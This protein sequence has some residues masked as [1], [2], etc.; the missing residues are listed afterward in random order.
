MGRVEAVPGSLLQT[1]AH[2]A[3]DARRD[4]PARPGHLGRVLL[5]DRVHRL[6]RA[7]ASERAHAREHLVKQRPEREDVRAVIHRLA[8]DLLGRHEAHRPQH[9]A[10]FRGPRALVSFA[11]ER[12]RA[13][14]LGEAEV[15]D[16]DPAVVRD[17]DVVGLEVAV[18]DPLVVSG[19]KAAGDLQRV[20]EGLADRKRSALEADL[21]GVAFEQLRDDV[22]GA[23]VRADIVDGEDVR[24]VQGAG[25]AGLLLEAA[26]LLGIGDLLGENLDRDL[27]LQAG[28]TGAVDLTHRPR[29]EQPHDLVRAESRAGLE[30]HRYTPA[31]SPLSL[32][33]TDCR[34]VKTRIAAMTGINRRR[35]R[36]LSIRHV[37]AAGGHRSVTTRET[38]CGAAGPGSGS[39]SAGDRGAGLSSG[40]SSPDR[41]LRRL[42]PAIRRRGPFHP[43]PRR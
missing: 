14:Q 16:L 11:D 34:L 2:E 18:D 23:V 39:R 25:G 43:T 30:R 33:G 26:E 29:G 31:A 22:G 12:R 27:A 7:V 13:R 5:Q 41:P 20:V 37:P 42:F 17:E 28:V 10:R 21:Q 40:K 9:H 35:T 38:S 19:G 6:D 3:R 32:K 24:V 1:A 4:S 15:E 36:G 8:P